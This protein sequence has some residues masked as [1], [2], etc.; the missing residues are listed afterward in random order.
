MS[1]ETYYFSHDYNARNDPKLINLQMRMGHAGKGI[2]WDLVELMYQ[3]DGRLCLLEI[4]SYAFALRTDSESISKL[5][6]D[7]NLF[8]KDETHFWSESINKRLEKRKEKSEK[9]SKSARYKWD[10][11]NAMRTHSDGNAIKDNKGKDNKGNNKSTNVDL[12]TEKNKSLFGEEMIKEF[13]S[14]RSWVGDNAS[15]MNE[16]TEPM[17]LHQY[18]EMRKDYNKTQII[19]ICERMHNNPSLTKVYR[20]AYITLK[21]WIKNNEK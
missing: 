19:K 7:F 1:K 10:N 6:N 4:D 21:N 12:F 17:K 13:L 8:Q 16:M 3:E 18:A 9:A 2:F 20:S 14:F 15:T 5:I 11:A